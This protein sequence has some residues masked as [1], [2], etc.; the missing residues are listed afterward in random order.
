[1]EIYWLKQ[2]CGFE[3][4]I[5]TGCTSVVDEMMPIKILRIFWEKLMDAITCLHYI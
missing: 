1:M 5:H 3:E 2:K 4:I